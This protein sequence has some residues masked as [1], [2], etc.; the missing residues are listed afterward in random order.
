MPMKKTIREAFIIILI[1]MLLTLAFSILS[2]VGRILLKKGL[3][4]KTAAVYFLTVP[5]GPGN[6]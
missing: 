2:P 3:R 5:G 4:I 6:I 1:T